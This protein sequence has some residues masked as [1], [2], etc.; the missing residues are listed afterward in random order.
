MAK[1]IQLIMTA[2]LLPIFMLTEITAKFLNAVPAAAAMGLPFYFYAPIAIL[3][4]L[5]PVPFILLYIPKILDW[6]ATFRAFEGIV[7]WVRRKA[8]KH[9]ERILKGAFIGLLFFVLLPLPGTGA[10]TGALVAALLNMKTKY[11]LLSIFLGILT[12]GVIMTVG[13]ELVALLF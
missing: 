13:S 5:I 12:A 2:S 6:L 9:S 7:A 11:A 4:N 1:M 8:D 10:W 3:G